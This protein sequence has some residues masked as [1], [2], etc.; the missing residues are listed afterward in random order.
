MNDED[1]RPAE[2]CST[3]LDLAKSNASI[4]MEVDVPDMA[5]TSLS[6]MPSSPS[7]HQESKILKDAPSAANCPLSGLKTAANDAVHVVNTHKVETMTQP[8]SG[9]KKNF[10]S[11]KS[12]PLPGPENP[13]NMLSTANCPLSE[14]ETVANNAVHVVNTHKVETMTQPESGEKKNFQ[15]VKSTP[16]PGLETPS[17]ITR[18]AA[19][20]TV[21]KARHDEEEK[22]KRKADMV[23]SIRAEIG[24]EG[25][26]ATSPSVVKAV[27][28]YREMVRAQ[29]AEAHT[30]NV[31]PKMASIKSQIQPEKEGPS[32]SV[33]KLIQSLSTRKMYQQTA[34]RDYQIEKARSIAA[35]IEAARYLSKEM[36]ED[37]NAAAKEQPYE[38]E[39]SPAK[40]QRIEEENSATGEQR[41]IEEERATAEEQR[42]I[43]K[44][45][46]ATEEQRQ[47]QEERAAAEAQRIQEE[48]A[49]AEERRIQEERAAAD[50]R[51]IQEERAAAE[52]R[53]IQE[54]AAA[55]EERRIQEERAAAEEQRIQDER[56][57]AEARR[58]QEEAAAVEEWRIREE[59][60]AAEEQRIQDERAAAEERRI[61]EE[62]AVA[63]EQRIQEEKPYLTATNVQQDEEELRRIRKAAESKRLL[64]QKAFK[65]FLSKGVTL[66]KHARN[67]KSMHRILKWKAGNDELGLVGWGSGWHSLS[68]CTEVRRGTDLDP[69]TDGKKGTATLNACK[70]G[71]MNP[72]QSF[73]LIFT[74]RTLDFSAPTKEQC[75]QL[76]YH[77]RSLIRSI[78]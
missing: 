28:V 43:Q 64:E 41:R 7:K 44:E 5:A 37:S 59:R 46:A 32:P 27:K 62:R 14:L 22:R 6:S 48:R 23:E 74:D 19:K 20:L 1:D 31:D 69:L 21:E 8:E 77:F 9:E 11:V 52:A 33:S 13:S 75:N 51:R 71:R 49:V 18:I 36:E 3:S 24:G 50:E 78:S 66:L 67:G 39:R 16:L 38:E 65:E 58:I 47:I 26:S 45:R 29:D 70:E 73:S 55:V 61:Q 42:R 68:A 15:S 25:G 40:K 60:A 2:F 12:T 57:A 4:C 17:H 10:Q 63:E 30:E 34:S 56:A 72:G 53:R 76:V 54:E 35:E